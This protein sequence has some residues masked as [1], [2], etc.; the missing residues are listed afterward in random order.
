MGGS[1]LDFVG[2]LLILLVVVRDLDIV[3]IAIAPTETDSKLIVDPDAELAGTI[4]SELFQ[5]K[6]R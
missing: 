5:T 6:A 1:L 3:G 4:P 2:T